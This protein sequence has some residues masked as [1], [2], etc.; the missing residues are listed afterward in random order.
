MKLFVTPEINES[1][2]GG[3]FSVISAHKKKLQRMGVKYVNSEDKADLV[4][5]HALADT[6]KRPDVFHSHGFYPTIQNGWDNRFTTANEHLFQT[7]M[8][9]RAVVSVS[10]LAA[11]VMRRDFHIQPLI[12]RNGVD[13]RETSMGGRIDGHVLW[14]KMTINPTCDPAPMKWLAEKRS[15]LPLLSLMP[16]S[17]KIK[18]VGKLPRKDFLELLRD[19]SIYLGTTRENNSMGEMEAMSCGIPVVGFNWGFNREWL[20]SGN[21]CEL[22][23]PGDMEALSCAITKV[24]LRWNSYHKDA[25]LFAVANFGWDVPI[26]QIYKLYESLLAP[27]PAPKVSV[28]IPLYNYGRWINDAVQSAKSQTVHPCEIIVVDDA[29]TDNPVIPAGVKLIRFKKNQGVAVARNTGIAEAKGDLILCLDADDKIL[30]KAIEMLLPKFSNPRVGIAY[31]PLVLMDENGVDIPRFWFADEFD[32]FLHR[33]GKTQIPTC[34]MFRKVLWERVGGFRSYEKPAED[35][36]FW[37]RAASQGWKVANESK[38]PMLQYRTHAAVSEHR[39]GSETQLNPVFDWWRK[40]RAWSVRNSGAG[41]KV[42]I[43]DCPLVSFVISYQPDKE[44]EF[45]QTID[46]I[47]GLSETEWEICA[48]GSP[49]PLIKSG[50]PFIRWGKETSGKIVTQTKSG[51]IV[52]DEIWIKIVS[53]KEFPQ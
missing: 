43:Y 25:R 10:E 2:S 36:A 50:Y 5:V 6:Q 22:V 24:L 20:E 14:P 46:S 30:P 11:E 12:I 37:L 40:G 28:V 27:E 49:R 19:C 3:V 18:T 53:F 35:A 16:I 51:E 47:E 23:E 31:A 39:A 21:G 15:D 7:M 26:D 34:A 42:R 44:K 9:A 13:F 45:I 52:T 38:Y 4:I 41:G 17:S 32:Y 8:T 48:E 1:S 29:S 33:S